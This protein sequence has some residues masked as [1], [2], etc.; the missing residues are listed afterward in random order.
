MD[1]WSAALTGFKASGSGRQRAADTNA[2]AVKN[3]LLMM[4]SRVLLAALHIDVMNDQDVVKPQSSR[5]SNRCHMSDERP[6][7]MTG[8][9]D[10]WFDTACQAEL[11]HASPL[12]PW[13]VP[14]VLR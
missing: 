7:A 6:A 3:S 11:L 5:I 12:I 4:A 9:A 2:I 8:Q 13:A 14:K 10:S 1:N